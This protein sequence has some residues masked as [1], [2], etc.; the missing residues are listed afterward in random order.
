[1]A[2]GMEQNMY[3]DENDENDIYGDVEEDDQ[4]IDDYDAPQS[5]NDV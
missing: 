5:N 4:N 1:M 3:D 2:T